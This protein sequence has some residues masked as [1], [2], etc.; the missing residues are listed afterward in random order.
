MAVKVQITPDLLRQ[1][2]D[3]HPAT[4]R[5]FWHERPA[6]LFSNGNAGSESNAKAWNRRY[7]GRETFLNGTGSRYYKQ[8]LLG[9]DII[10]H[11]AAWV[12]FYGVFPDK[13]IDHIN[14]DGKDNR[15]S[16]L[17]LANG[18]QNQANQ[19]KKPGLS[20]R[21]KGVSWH[22]NYGKWVASG[23][24]HLG[25]FDNEEDAARAYDRAISIIHGEFAVLNFPDDAA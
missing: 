24:L 1:L 6:C 17:R 14:G 23:R 13:Q 21:F 15:I 25:Y 3:Y 11:I 12:I 20:S 22:R 10:A 9:V 5:F 18:S 19:R 2:L 7:A 8:P 16:N 4:G